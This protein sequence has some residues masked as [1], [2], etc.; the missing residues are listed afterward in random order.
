MSNIFLRF[1][2]LFG[3]AGMLLGYWMG[4]SHQ[5]SLSPVHAHINLLGWASMFLYGLF[6]RV[7]PGA[8]AGRLPWIHLWLAAV[9]L[10][11][12]MAGL[13]IQL[14]PLPALATVQAPLLAAG[15]TLIVLGMFVFALVVFRAT[16]A[17]GAS[18]DQAVIQ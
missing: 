16:G 7:F 11:I 13:T 4:M 2:V 10:P 6:Y 12:M 17:R 3:L 8:A 15:S 5:F 18:A 1:G 9:G 14:A